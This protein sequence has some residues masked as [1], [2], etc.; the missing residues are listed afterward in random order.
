MR[1]HDNSWPHDHS[2]QQSDVSLKQDDDHSQHAHPSSQADIGQAGTSY[3]NIRGNQAIDRIV[4]L[5][6]NATVQ[7]AGDWF[8]DDIPSLAPPQ[9][10]P[11]R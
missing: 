9:T 11:P 5:T 8:V 7:H 6:G 2:W 1:S 4:S 3:T 10:A